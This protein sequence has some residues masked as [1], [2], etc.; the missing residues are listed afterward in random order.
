M[1]SRGENRMGLARWFPAR[2]Q[3]LGSPLRCR[4][5]MAMAVDS[6]LHVAAAAGLRRVEQRYT[7]GRRTLVEV[8]DAASR[9]LSIPEILRQGRP[10]LPQSSVYRNL[11][12]LEQA[13]VV[14]RVVSTDEFAR[15]ELSEDLTSHHHHLVCSRCGNVEDFTPPPALERSVER[16]RS[17]IGSGMGFNTDAHRL[18]FIGT[19]RDCA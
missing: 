18:D 15:Y 5:M 1:S 4:L 16:A 12:V 6:D 9:P 17:S 19:C 10:R 8:L 14:R 7:A 11:G 13:G 2:S 3:M